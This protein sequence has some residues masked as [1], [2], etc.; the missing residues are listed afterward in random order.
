VKQ[1]KLRVGVIGVGHQGEYHVQK[2]RALPTVELVGVVDTN[3]DRAHEIA[4]RF[5]TT[6]YS[7]H[8][9]ILNMV[10][11]VSLA[12]PTAV[13]FDVAKDILS[14]GVH[15][16]IEKPITYNLEP[17]DALIHMAR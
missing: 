10:D 5:D 7:E 4:Q 12:I 16:L 13:I 6:A 17:A 8:N 1:E 14:R 9:E 2:Y 3:P 15:L 11:G